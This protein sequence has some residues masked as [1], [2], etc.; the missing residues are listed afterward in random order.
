MEEVAEISEGAGGGSSSA[1]G[2]DAS[3][4]MG[5]LSATVLSRVAAALR[6]TVEKRWS[7]SRRTEPKSEPAT[8]S[9]GRDGVWGSEDVV[10]ERRASRGEG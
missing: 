1:H 6:E 9:R 3:S 4:S 10:G 5:D 8:E 2:F 7:S